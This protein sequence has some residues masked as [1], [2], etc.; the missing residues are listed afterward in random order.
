MLPESLREPLR[1]A[2]IA[3]RD[4]RDRRA[5][6]AA[7]SGPPPHVVKVDAIRE[8]A[9]RFHLPI[10]IET[11]TFEGE[12]ARKCS[13]YFREIYTIEL[14][15]GLAT[16]ATRRLARHRNVRVI[17]GDSAACLAQVVAG[18]EG[19]A[20]FWLDAHYS[21]SGT[22]KGDIETPIAAEIAAIASRPI[23]GHVILID[24]ARLLGSGDY[25]T[26]EELAR[27]L[28]RVDPTGRVEVSD[29][30]VRF[31]PRR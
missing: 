17:Q 8:H 26:L 30:I 10:L 1:A 31:T 22:A 15:P 28:E 24:D 16:A 18:L 14:D 11:G 27:L 19:P 2:V 3:R 5:Y 4:A 23:S 21:G 9:A 20:L 29:D 7:A 6:R 13:P 25:P 12:M